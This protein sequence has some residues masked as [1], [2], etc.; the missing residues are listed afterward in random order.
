MTNKV[1]FEYAFNLDAIVEYCKINTGNNDKNKKNSEFRQQEIS[2]SYELNELDNLVLSQKVVHEVITPQ[3][4]PQYDEMKSELVKT[5]FLTILN[6]NDVDE[7]GVPKI[8]V[9]G[10]IAMQTFLDNGFL[11]IKYTEDN[12]TNND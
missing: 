6:N 9:P 2:N 10:L 3:D 1:L 8:G 11:K 5:L 7:N 4:T 12:E